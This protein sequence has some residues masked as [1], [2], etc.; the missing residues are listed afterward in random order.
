MYCS[1]CGKKND[2]DAKFCHYCGES[3]K[4]S[5]KSSAKLE[6][7]SNGFKEFSNAE[8]ATHLT[9]MYLA[10]F[11]LYSLVWISNNWGYIKKYYRPEINI[12]L[13]TIGLFVPGLNLFLVYSQFKDLRDFAI[14]EG[15]DTKIKPFWNMVCFIFLNYCFL[16]FLQLNSI[17]KE[18]NR[19]WNK[20]QPDLKIRDKFSTPEIVWITLVSALV[21]FAVLGGSN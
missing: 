5:K 15:V 16:G 2:H 3:V 1:K 7:N 19:V 4:K 9:V 11:E 13:R 6:L 20:L 12:T 18:L 8:N 10:T 17:Q 14:K 21:V